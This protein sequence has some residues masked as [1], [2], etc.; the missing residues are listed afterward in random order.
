MK[1]AIAGY[2]IEGRQNLQYFRQRYPQAEIVIAD[3]RPV[4]DAPDD[5]MVLSGDDVFAT[6]LHDV[7][8]V[9]RTASLPPHDIQTT[10]DV[11]SATNEFFAMCPAPIIGVTGTK[12]KGTTCSF[13]AS[14]LR[15]AGKTVY[16]VGNIG[17]PALSVLPEIQPDDV[18]VY[19]LSSFQL[20]DI[21]RSPQVAVILMIEPDHLDKHRDFAEYCR[22]KANIVRYQQADDTVVYNQQNQYSRDIATQSQAHHVTYPGNVADDILDAIVLPGRHNR[23]NASAAVAAVRALDPAVSD[24]ELRQGLAAFTGLPHRLK[25]VAEKDHVKYYDDSISTTPGSAIAAMRAFDQP[26][27][28]ILGGSDKGVDYTKLAR[29]LAQSSS[30]R[31]AVVAGGNAETVIVALRQA[32]VAESAIIHQTVARMSDIVRTAMSA[33]QPGDV[34]VLSPAAA[35]FDHYTNYADRGEQFVAAVMTMERME[36]IT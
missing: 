28:L 15:A 36:E 18:V 33:A 23:D 31:A 35:S 12:G 21:Q 6:Q 25:F 9:V 1:I 5:V 30:L 7:D 10:G 27:V 13:I 4:H 2:G 26:K 24:D 17:T 3:Q 11:W 20:W 19:E 32:G 34:V 16:L 14:I 8:L 29:E 22:A